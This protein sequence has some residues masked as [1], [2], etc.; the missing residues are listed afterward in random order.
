V[1]D[2]YIIDSGQKVEVYR[3]I[4][5]IRV[6]E[7]IADLEEELVDRY[8]DLPGPVERLLMVSKIKVIAS[9]LRIKNINRQKGTFNFLFGT[10]PPLDAARL[11]K[12]GEMYRNRIK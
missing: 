8:G 2:K 12:L 3:R 7:Q 6:G 11:V 9:E 10:Q 4:A 5:A 1:P